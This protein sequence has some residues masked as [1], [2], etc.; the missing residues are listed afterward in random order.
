MTT[1]MN[2]S[3]TAVPGI[4]VGHFTHL[5][6]GTGCT[7]VLCPPN[8]VGGVD[9]RGGAPGT[10]ETDL[11]RPTHHVETVNAVLLS[12]GSAYGLA[13]SVGVM[14]YLE[15]RETGYRS[16]AGYIVPIVP[17]AILFDLTVGSS[18]IRPDADMG[19]AACKAASAEPV[20]QGTV[21]AGTGCRIGAIYGN[22]RST[23]GGIGSAALWIDDDL[24]VAA[25]VAVNAV[26]DVLA[27]DGHI[28]AGVRAAPDSGEFSGMLNALRELARVTSSPGRDNTVIGVVA[29]NARLTKEQVNK[30]AQMGNSGVARTVNPAHT[31][32]DGDTMFALATGEIEA[33]VSVVGA[34]AAEAVAQAV[35][36]AVL[37]AT[38]LFDVRAVRDL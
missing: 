14:R 35:Q 38:T 1:R 18:T 10:R 23:K 25:L 8:T 11:L 32:Y 17:S 37:E 34:F 30:L 6:G 22:A 19:Y 9:Q 21:G 5:E 29:T 33:N 13:A 24:V 28:L 27:E 3:L 26:G 16:G 2:N 15:E 4:Q 12:G 20:A 7:V 36:N 31:M